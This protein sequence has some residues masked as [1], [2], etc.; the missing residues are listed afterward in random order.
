LLPPPPLLASCVIAA[1]RTA[2]GTGE[3]TVNVSELDV[4]PHV[5]PVP[6]L[7]P[8][9]AGVLTVTRTLDA[10]AMSAAEIAAVSP[11]TDVKV[12]IGALTF[13][14]TFH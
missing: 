5:I 11:F 8:L 1:G 9:G 12:V 2:P 3:K 6:T 4:P 7:Q 10:A 13:P 14:L